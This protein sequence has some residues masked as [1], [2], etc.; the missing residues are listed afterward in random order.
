MPDK[1]SVIKEVQKYLAKGQIDKA[2][3]TWVKL[4]KQYPDGNTY[5]ALG[6]LYLKNS[7][8]KNALNSF[9]EAAK[10][11]RHEG[12]SLKAL[13][14]YKKI[15]NI[16][17]AN[18][19]ALIS[20]GEINEERGLKMDAVKYYL[21]A[22]DTLTKEG[23]KERILD[24]YDKI[25]A[26]SPSNIPFRIKIAEIY[27]KEGLKSE[28]A[29]EYLNIARVYEE[30][31]DIEK[32]MEHYQKALYIHPLYKEA[33]LGINY[34][35]E[36]SGNLKKAIEHMKEAFTLFPQ[37]TDIYLRRAE[38]YITGEMFDEAKECL[39]KITEH[40]PAHMKA[41]RLL[42]DIY[43]KKGN[44][45][46]AWTIYLPVLDEMMLDMK[47]EDAIKLLKSFKDIDPLEV[48]KRLVILYRQLGEN[49]SLVS[50]FVALG[51]LYS[52][53]G[54]HNEALE[55][56]KEALLL[57]PDDDSLKAKVLELEKEAY[58][59]HVSIK[60][61][62]PVEEDIL[63]V[64]IFLKYGLIEDAR[65]LLEK[66]RERKPENIDLHLRLKSLYT[67]TDDKERALEECFILSE[68]YEKASDPEKRNQVMKEAYTISPEDPRL[69]GKVE[70]PP[71]VTVS[72]TPPEGPSIEDY[73]EEITEADFYSRQGLID[74][75]REILERLKKLFPEN[76]E[77][78]QKLASL[79]QEG[80]IL[81]EEYREPIAA[82]GETLETE[83]VTEPAFDS[84]VLSMFSEF[85][86]GLEKELGD[87]NHETHY[88]L[89]LAYKE[90][91]FIDDAIREF[92]LSLNDPGS[93]IPSS[94]MLSIC[95][96]EKGLYTL[97]ID[98]LRSALNKMEVKDESYWAMKY[99]LAEAYEKNSNFQEAFDL[100]TEV[101]G[102]N[103]KFRDVS[104]KLNKIGPK[105]AEKAEKGKPKDRKD[106]I[107]YL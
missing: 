100:Y 47:K 101:Y 53:K 56:Y 24:I 22:A 59:E 31:G 35:Y 9:R 1:A 55:C 64:D 28:A 25:L 42:G 69:V 86:K 50:E 40:E 16:N 18:A 57:T 92:Q 71:E 54:I 8:K 70:I 81:E 72:A 105:V 48:G 77:I 33:I 87:K 6:D 75:A 41:V 13:G 14:L 23:R 34:L 3:A 91:G 68:L 39:E 93:F 90:L 2:I 95:Y 10:F 45:E 4:T 65:N 106:R 94:S 79:V 89:G 78:R 62:K 26:I 98:V 97:A 21:T 36:K 104:E 80:K 19:D 107:S 63:E 99:D 32:S 43:I 15:L 37:D 96:V 85:K 66:I 27:T 73:V 44:M 60:G 84:D 46:K 5:N 49:V 20:L 51:N 83:T 61:E 58:A 82:G 102:W 11:F 52:A 67:D 74:E 30:K 88:N 38:I 103:S 76:E 12:F 17:P 29:K 7:D